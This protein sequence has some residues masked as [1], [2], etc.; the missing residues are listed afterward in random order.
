MTRSIGQREWTLLVASFLLV[1]MAAKIA[2]AQEPE[3]AASSAESSLDAQREQLKRELAEV[4]KEL[5]NVKAEL[6]AE[7][8]RAER[9]RAEAKRAKAR[10]RE[11]DERAIETTEAEESTLEKLQQAARFVTRQGLR[12]STDVEHEDLD[13]G[14]HKEHRKTRAK[15]TSKAKADAKPKAQEKPKHHGGERIVSVKLN[16]DILVVKRPEANDSTSGNSKPVRQK[17]SKVVVP[18]RSD[19]TQPESNPEE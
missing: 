16:L 5:E 4:R 12:L 17:R 14:P 7:R 1:G 13:A 9:E 15:E 19:D 3:S 11:E 8:A 6:R 10:Q 18:E 2:P